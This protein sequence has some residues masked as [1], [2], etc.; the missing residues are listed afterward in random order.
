MSEL[1]TRAAVMLLPLP[2]CDSSTVAFWRCNGLR[3]NTLCPSLSTHIS[4]RDVWPG[5][6]YDAS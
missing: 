5:P 2:V 3:P 1:T 6:E 4:N